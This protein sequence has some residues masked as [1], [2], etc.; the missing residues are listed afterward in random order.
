[1]KAIIL[2]L[3]FWGPLKVYA[4]QKL[5]AF[6]RTSE[7]S[8]ST[9]LS[10]Q[11]NRVRESNWSTEVFL[12][13]TRSKVDD[14]NSETEVTRELQWINQWDFSDVWFY[15]L[16]LGASNTKVNKIRTSNLDMTLGRVHEEFYFFNWSITAGI[17]NIKQQDSNG[18]NRV[19][20][21][22]VQQKTGIQLGI[23]PLDWLSLSLFSNRYRYNKDVDQAL[24]SL[25]SEAA[26]RRYGTA[27]SDQLSSL[28]ETE[29]GIS[30]GFK[31]N[32]DCRLSFS[33][34]QTQ[35]APEPKVQGQSTS[36]KMFYRFNSQWDSSVSASSTQYESTAS[37]PEAEYSY[38]GLGVGY[39]W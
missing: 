35:D 12:N 24:L 26:I 13:A 23:D 30:L 31:L 14:V 19:A 8:N 33:A 17:N 32:D 11:H 10:Y 25:Q 36:V 2:F 29:S 21:S 4:D 7:S 9:T 1:M 28:I 16:G 5:E 38:L 6:L 18:P 3:I 34:S 27:F 39:S 20:L 22:L 37:T 15:E